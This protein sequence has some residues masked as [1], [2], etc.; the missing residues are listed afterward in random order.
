[1]VSFPVNEHPYSHFTLRTR[2]HF[3]D[4]WAK[5]ET[6]RNKCGYMGDCHIGVVHFTVHRRVRF[7]GFG[8]VPPSVVLRP[9]FDR[10]N[11]YLIRGD[12]QVNSGNCSRVVPCQNGSHIRE[13]N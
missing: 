4:I 2:I 5:E 13:T 8:Q 10:W 11:V 6:H 7:N 12:Q 3:H 9:A 1:M